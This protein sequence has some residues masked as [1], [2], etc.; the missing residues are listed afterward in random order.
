M[1][2]QRRSQHLEDLDDW[3]MLA[4][5][6]F[7]V[8]LIVWVLFVDPSLADEP[9]VLILDA[10]I[11]GVFLIEFLIRW[12]VESW[13]RWFPLKK[14]YE[15]LGMIPMIA[16][17]SPVLR[18]FRLLRIVVVLFRLVNAADRAFGEKF[19]FRVVDRLSGP[20][21]RAIKTPITAAVLDEVLKVIGTADFPKHIASAVNENH[22]ELRAIIAEKLAADPQTGR[23]KY[24][25]FHDQIVNSAVDTTIR[26]VLEVL[27][28]ERIDEF[29]GDLVRESGQQIRDAVW[30]GLH[31]MP[32]TYGTPAN[33]SPR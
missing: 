8:G 6:V 27:G 25:P 32:S 3:A 11:C 26:L 15:I 2:E 29:I 1:V 19:T 33:L 31:E 30:E 10:A 24:V 12:R 16:L 7:S 20:I 4:L 28:D 23:I 21:V 22:D 13:N 9:W 17:A 5:A 14:W 18:G